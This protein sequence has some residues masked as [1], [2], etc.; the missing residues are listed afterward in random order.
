MADRGL[1]S[2]WEVEDI[3][4]PA[5]LYLRVHINNL[6]DKQLH[7]GVVREQGEDG[8]S[9]D[10]DKYSTPQEARLRAKKPEK[11]GI[12]TLIAGAV[13]GIEGVD[14]IHDPIRDPPEPNRAHS[15]VVGMHGRE[16]MVRGLLFEQVDH[17][18]TIN[19]F[20]QQND[21]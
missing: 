15:L 5:R 16:T 8:M 10:W 19:P 6:R 13:R 21:S 11:V 17:N 18:W 3:P 20:E 14:V 9:V 2:D 4:N 12:V 7:P 1:T